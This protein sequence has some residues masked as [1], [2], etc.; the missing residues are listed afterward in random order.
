MNKGPHPD[1]G[2]FCAAQEGEP[3]A[4]RVCCIR[5]EV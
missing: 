3:D 2:Y 1:F 5:M 4:V